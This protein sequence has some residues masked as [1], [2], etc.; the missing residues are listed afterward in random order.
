M[1]NSL[2][3]IMDSF[4]ECFERM[5]VKEED[6]QLQFELVIRMRKKIMNMKEV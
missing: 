1:E 3:I 2:S 6:T 5:N 4:Y